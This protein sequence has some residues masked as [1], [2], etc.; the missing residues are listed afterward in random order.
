MMTLLEDIRTVLINT[1]V[2]NTSTWKCWIQYAPDNADQ[3]ISLHYTGGMPQDTLAGENIRPTFQLRI[4]ASGL[5]QAAAQAK[6]WDMFAALHDADLS[7]YGIHLIQSGATGP[8]E[9]L[10]GG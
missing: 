4:R 5:D 2:A 7:A 3:C 8:L 6:W 1:G 10:M 9:W